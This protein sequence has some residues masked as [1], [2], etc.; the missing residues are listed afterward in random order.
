MEK[1]DL[2]LVTFFK[3]SKKREIEGLKLE[4]ISI[5]LIYLIGLIASIGSIILLIINMSKK[6]IKSYIS[7]LSFAIISFYCFFKF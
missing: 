4:N 7:I 1:I 6:K 5:D 3:E 2:F